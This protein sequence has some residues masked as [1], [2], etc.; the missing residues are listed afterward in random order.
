[1][2]N[3][4]RRAFLLAT[5][6]LA[7]CAPTVQTQEAPP[8]ALSFSDQVN[9]WTAELVRQSPETATRYALDETL[10][11]GRYKDRLDDRSAAGQ[12]R[13]R[14]LAIRLAR[15][16]GAIDRAA[17]SDADK[18]TY[19]VLKGAF[20]VAAG[21]AAVEGGA[22][23]LGGGGNPYVLD[24]QA[25]AFINLPDFFDSRCNIANADDAEAYVARLNQVAGALDSELAIAQADAAIGIMPPD[26]ILDKTIRAADAALAAPLAEQ[27]YLTGLKRKLDALVGSG[28]MARAQADAFYAQGEA[29]T[30]DQIL[31]AHERTAAHLRAQRASA[32][33]DAGVWR[34][35]N[36]AA[37]YQASLRFFTTTNLTPDEIHE[38][39]L[40][41]VAELNARADEAL[42]REGLTRGPVGARLA[43]ITRDPRRRYPNTDAGRA[44]ILGDTR[45]RISRV[46]ARAPEWFA[47]LPRAGIEVRRMPPVVEA[48]QSAAYYNAPALDGSHPGVYYMTLR[49][50]N[51]VSRVD[52]ATVTHHEA[53]P[54]HHFQIALAQ[55]QE[56]IPLIRRLNNFN[57][58]T[59]GWALYAEQLVDEMGFYDDD[60]EGRIGHLRWALWRGVRL[61]VDTG[62]H[63][64]RWTR[65]Q[66]VQ[67][68]QE[69]L[70]DDPTIIGNE[71]DRYAAWPGQACGYELGR[72]E[73]VR[74]REEARA[75]MGARFDLR[76]FHDAV[77]LN[78]SLPL[79]VLEA[80]VHRWAG[81]SAT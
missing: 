44:Q 64:K 45:A 67:Y 24:Q 41:R 12:G 62:L 11:G 38:I 75:A 13:Q 16:L 40:A 56:S 54:G 3:V 19:D 15:D 61:V 43:Q 17:L 81:I 39:G 70:G 68:M 59:E 4:S 72:R 23:S 26:F 30:R 22:Y 52:L 10:M 48:V 78:G 69:N 42:R 27:V 51:T 53:V 28:A 66:T 57:A 14:A 9:A 71:C 37:Y 58:Y 80:Q 33:H 34:T 74:L 7:A 1:M 8:I 50:M 5:A 60:N 29:I 20:D 47:H 55:E 35:P 25:S 76:G 6:A 79:T 63:H 65:E 32:T 21:V 2:Q 18:L 77:L 36:G 73:I 31:P 46:M 49:D